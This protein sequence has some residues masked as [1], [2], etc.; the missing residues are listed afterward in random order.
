ME[1][2]ATKMTISMTHTVCHTAYFLSWVFFGSDSY[3]PISYKNK[4]LDI[5]TVMEIAADF[6]SHMLKWDLLN[7]LS[8]NLFPIFYLAHS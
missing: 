6:V 8:S 4:R 3:P 2:A 5:H 7:T 1:G